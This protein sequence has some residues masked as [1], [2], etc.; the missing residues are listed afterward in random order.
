MKKSTNIRNFRTGGRF[1]IF[2]ILFILLCGK[3]TAQDSVT[4]NDVKNI[5]ARAEFMIT[6]LNG[7]LNTISST[8]ADN[9]DIRQMINNSMEEGVRKIFLNS[10][11]T[12]AD[13][14]SS[15]NFR[16]SASSHDVSVEQYLNDFNTL[17]GKSD[18]HSVFFQNIR[19]S[20]VKRGKENLF[21]K[22]YYTSLF[23]NKCKASPDTPYVLTNREAEIFSEAVG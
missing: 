15:P 5:A 22:V 1:Y 21:V 9:N 8:G 14:I 20:N 19:T 6:N 12:I 23:K 3:L 2:M 13:D 11:I 4:L 17:Y 16:N 7:L 18:A 10:R